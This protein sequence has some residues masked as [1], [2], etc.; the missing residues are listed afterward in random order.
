MSL[1]VVLFSVWGLVTVVFAALLLYRAR[2]TNQESDWINL[3]D[4]AREERA[5]QA[6]TIIE[7]KTRKLTVPIRAL[8]TLSVVLLLVILG[9]WIYYGITTPP[10]ISE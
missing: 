9:V 10:P 8:G 7:M 3:T 4:D 6:Q 5:I 2:L 1:Y